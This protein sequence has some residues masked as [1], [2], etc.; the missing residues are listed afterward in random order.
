EGYLELGIQEHHAAAAAGAMSCENMVTF[1]S[2]FG[3][4]AVSEV[5][6]APELKNFLRRPVLAERVWTVHTS[7]FQGQSTEGRR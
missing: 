5:Y 6:N 4:F 2:T 1:F 3:S 7:C